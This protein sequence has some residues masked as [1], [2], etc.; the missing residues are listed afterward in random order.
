MR[1]PHQGEGGEG[2]RVLKLDVLAEAG[3]RRGCVDLETFA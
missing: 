1:R 2:R 3:C